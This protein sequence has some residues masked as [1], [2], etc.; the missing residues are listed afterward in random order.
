MKRLT[1]I[2]LAVLLLWGCA[3]G[4][5]MD[6]ALEARTKFQSSG[7][8]FRATISADYGDMIHTFVLDCAADEKGDVEFTVAAPDTISGITGRLTGESGFLTF[9]GEV[10]AFS[11]LADGQLSPVSAPWVLIHTLRGGYLRACG[12]TE[13]GLRLTID[14]SYADNSMQVDIW[15]DGE[16]I[17]TG[18]EVL[19]QGRRIL[20]VK[21]E[22]F[23]FV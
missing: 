9:D 23:E 16:N 17:P 1:G 13:S 10:L 12:E 2:L 20:T 11:L 4:D 6:R 3:A 18:A 7:C 8:R 21:V 19:W 14:D 5:G 15:L 22:S